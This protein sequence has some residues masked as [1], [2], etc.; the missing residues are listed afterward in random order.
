MGLRILHLIDSGGLYG[1]ERMLLM[2]VEEQL[3][4]GL[5]P[6]ILSAGE[7]HIGTKPIEEEA[8]RLALP[9]IPWRMSKGLN[10]RE[11]WKILQWAKRNHYQVLHS[12]G[13][14]FNILTGFWPA[15]LRG[16]PVVTTLHGYVRAP[17]RSRMAAYEALDRWMLTR[18][19]RIVIVSEGMR[20][21][22]PPSVRQPSRC[23]YIPNGISPTPPA[24]AQLPGPVVGFLRQ[25]KQC[26]LAVGRLS[27][28]KGFNYLVD[29]FARTPANL[30]QTGLVIIGEGGERERLESEIAKHGLEKQILLAGYQQ[31]AAAWMPHF[32]ALVMPSLTEGLPITILEALR[33][34]LPIIASAVGALPSLLGDTDSA[35]LIPPGDVSALETAL[36]NWAIIPPADKGATTASSLRPYSAVA[37]AEGYYSVYRDLLAGMA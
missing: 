32:D 23:L 9:V 14:K 2:L 36:T 16:L 1:A 24:P 21:L 20:R 22:V 30:S 27:R 7:P 5:E 11:A 17:R 3:R 29:V 19:D 34:D 8:H 35:T 18:L 28:E 26:L 31:N 12:H 6:M 33:A 4:Q 25:H 13:Y 15:W 10:L 37:M